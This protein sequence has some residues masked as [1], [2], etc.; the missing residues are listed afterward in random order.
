[1]AV[2]TFKV[3]I[4]IR[5]FL[6]FIIMFYYRYETSLQNFERMR[7]TVAKISIWGDLWLFLDLRYQFSSFFFGFI[8]IMSYY[9]YETSPQ[10]I[11]R[12][13][14]TVAKISTLRWDTSAN[15]G[16]FPRKL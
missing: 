9:S 4:F 7:P 8:I 6:F 10:I 11:K 5:F 12:M 1:M 3:S 2:F 16:T 13:C 14:P 15:H